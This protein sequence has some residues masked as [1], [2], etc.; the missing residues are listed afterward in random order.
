MFKCRQT[1]FSGLNHFS[2]GGPVVY[3]FLQEH[4]REQHKNAHQLVLCVCVFL[5]AAVWLAALLTDASVRP[6]L[7]F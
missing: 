5:D 1:Q 3:V 7:F 2:L 6:K 4:L